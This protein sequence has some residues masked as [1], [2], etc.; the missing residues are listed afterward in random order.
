VKVG[1]KRW[2]EL[3]AMGPSMYFSCVL[4]IIMVWKLRLGRQVRSR[5]KIKQW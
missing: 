4:V 1:E 2:D 5:S 3:P